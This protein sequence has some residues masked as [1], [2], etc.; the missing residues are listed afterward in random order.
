MLPAAEHRS[1]LSTTN[2]ASAATT[3]FAIAFTFAF[4]FLY[5]LLLALFNNLATHGYLV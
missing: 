5:S 2:S 3:P 1:H 4:V